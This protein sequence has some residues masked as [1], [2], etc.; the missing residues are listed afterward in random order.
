[1]RTG[2]TNGFGSVSCARSNDLCH[3]PRACLIVLDSS[4]QLI[5]ED[6]F[7]G[8]RS[9]LHMRFSSAAKNQALKIFLF[10]SS[11]AWSHGVKKYWC[12]ETFAVRPKDALNI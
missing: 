7:V 1:M 9:S 10:R 3:S 4:V 2:L 5:L 8:N 12:L 6:M 11:A